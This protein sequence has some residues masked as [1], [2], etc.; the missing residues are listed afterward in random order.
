MALFRGLFALS[1]ALLFLVGSG[2]L[3]AGSSEDLLSSSTTTRAPAAPVSASSSSGEAEGTAAFF[4]ASS[5]STSTAPPSTALVPLRW[6]FVPDH[7]DLDREGYPWEWLDTTHLASRLSCRELCFLP[8]GPAEDEARR[9]F[10]LQHNAA[11][12]DRL[13]Q[14]ANYPGLSA[15][16]GPE[17][18][19][20]LDVLRSLALAAARRVDL[21][22]RLQA[23][24]AAFALAAIGDTEVPPPAGALASAPP[25]VVGPPPS[26]ESEVGGAQWSPGAS[27]GE[28]P[29]EAPVVREAIV[30]PV[31]A[32][33]PLEEDA[34]A[35]EVAVVV[36]SDRAESEGE[37]MGS[38]ADSDSGSEEEEEGA[39]SPSPASTISSVGGPPL[40]LEGFDLVG[41]VTGTS[42]PRLQ[43]FA[44]GVSQRLV[45][46]F[47]AVREIVQP[48]VVE[49]ADNRSDV[50]SEA[51]QTSQA[52]RAGLRDRETALAGLLWPSEVQAVRETLGLNI[53]ESTHPSSGER[54]EKY[55]TR[56][57]VYLS[58][59]RALGRV[60]ERRE[61]KEEK[62]GKKLFP[63]MGARKRGDMGVPA[64]YAG[65]LAAE[66]VTWL[67]LRASLSADD[68]T[69]FNQMTGLSLPSAGELDIHCSISVSDSSSEEDVPDAGVEEEDEEDSV[70]DGEE[71]DGASA[72]AD[73]DDSSADA[74]ADDSQGEKSLEEEG[75][76]SATEDSPGQ[77]WRPPRSMRTRDPRVV[78]YSQIQQSRERVAVILGQ[79]YL[80]PRIKVKSEARVHVSYRKR[81]L[82]RVSDLLGPAVAPSSRT[83]PSLV[84]VELFS[85][86]ASLSSSAD[87]SS[88]ST[89]S[90]TP[91][92]S[93]SVSTGEGRRRRELSRFPVSAQPGLRELLRL[94]AY[95]SGEVPLPAS[96]TRPM[97]LRRWSTRVQDCRRRLSSSLWEEF[98]SQ[99]GVDVSGNAP[100]VPSQEVES[101]FAASE[102]VPLP[103][104]PGMI[105][106]E[107]SEEPARA[108]LF[109]AEVSILLRCSARSC[110]RG[111]PSSRGVVCLLVVHRITT[112]RGGLSCGGA[113]ALR[114]DFHL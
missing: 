9:L 46:L 50:G 97:V 88:S 20:Q 112:R 53:P 30:S 7:E 16:T 40:V 109:G 81:F 73:A 29:L 6:G 32:S 108:S 72:D 52:V 33:E 54:L 18:L 17:R 106:S 1:C 105:P 59:L 34:P 15:A 114:S 4:P 100:S 86:A 71:G 103:S 39:R 13:Q 60:A 74:D 82:R 89:S 65:E 75:S 22:R 25:S 80:F 96:L 99:T 77:R 113:T 38:E 111:V 98:C 102:V 93:P 91:P 8:L 49:E 94:R 58:N 43:R 35:E 90:S 56:L 31:A 37:V 5:S 64:V 3:F 63:A 76:S 28:L 41:N 24:R 26:V 69:D 67:R 79:R 47:Q 92:P 42:D 61:R 101:P 84:D 45:D 27:A 87:T 55:G 70:V 85:R 68:F 11:V 51:S 62:A 2:P 83:A 57:S 107:G 48:P 14:T 78:T 110:P 23:V 66:G 36:E 12:R 21:R 95:L 44:P 19:K 10:V 104:E